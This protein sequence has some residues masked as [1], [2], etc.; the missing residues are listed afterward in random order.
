M[1]LAIIKFYKSNVVYFYN[2]LLSINLRSFLNIVTNYYN[3]SLY[4]YTITFSSLIHLGMIYFSTIYIMDFL[5]N[6]KI[7]NFSFASF[8][9]NNIIAIFPDVICVFYNSNREIAIPFLLTNIFIALLLIVKPFYKLTHVAFH[10]LLIVQNY[11]LSLSIL[12]SD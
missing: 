9:T 11:Y 4:I 6:D 5:K 12:N 3:N 1:Y 7:D 8:R 2:D 10:A